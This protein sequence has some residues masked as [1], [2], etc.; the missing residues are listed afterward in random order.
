M[1]KFLEE[2]YQGCI[3][4]TGD[5]DNDDGD[6]DGDGDE[7][8]D[9]NTVETHFN[10]PSSLTEL[11]KNLQRGYTTPEQ[12]PDSVFAP[13]DLTPSEAL[14]LLHYIAWRKSNGTVLGYKLHAQVLQ[15]ANTL[16]ILSLASVRKLAAT[17]TDLEPEQVDMCPKSCLAYTVRGSGDPR[18]GGTGGT[19]GFV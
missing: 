4:F 5:D 11:R 18:T 7:T 17:L 12:C 16:E 13:R 15:H 9:I 2:Q 6:D 1:L 19:G 14:S 8:E 3:D 10:L